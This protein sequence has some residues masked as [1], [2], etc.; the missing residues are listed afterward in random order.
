MKCYL[1]TRTRTVKDMIE[2]RLS[3]ES[4]LQEANEHA[5]LQSIKDWTRVEDND[6][7]F[8]NILSDNEQ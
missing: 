2:V 5:K 7:Y 1:V 8:V 4:T 6:S 3:S